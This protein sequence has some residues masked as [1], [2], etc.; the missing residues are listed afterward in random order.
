[1]VEEP[2]SPA[3]IDRWAQQLTGE[4]R[5][6]LA[7]GEVP[8]VAGPGPTSTPLGSR[9]GSTGL[10]GQTG[11]NARG[12]RVVMK[13]TIV[14]NNNANPNQPLVGMSIHNRKGRK[15][16]IPQGSHGNAH[17]LTGVECEIGGKGG[18]P[19][20]FNLIYDWRGPNSSKVPLRNLR[21][22][23]QATA[24]PGPERVSVTLNSLSYVFPS[25][26][27]ISVPVSG[28]VVDAAEGI[29]GMVGSFNWNATKVMP[30]A[31]VSG[32]LQGFSEAL[33]S[34]S[35]VTVVGEASTTFAQTGD[36][37]EN[38]LYAGV[39]EGAGIMA[40]YVKR[41]LQDIKPS[42]SV[43]NGQKVTMILT[44]PVSFDVPEEEWDV[45][46]NPD[47]FDNYGA[48]P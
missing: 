2:Y 3:R 41:V 40:D 12:P 29:E 27:A 28:Y 13:P 32:G 1:V 22:I 38:A 39:G 24:M 25:G 36:Q 30:Y 46:T 16:T 43:R 17:L 26:R 42:I 48:V 21:V 20:M 31:V 8:R 11:P 35:T 4:V 44:Q 37:L 6:I 45:L 34:N 33:R 14:A 15:I 10:P 47:S 19:A 5:G 18:T 23:G 9:P 7:G